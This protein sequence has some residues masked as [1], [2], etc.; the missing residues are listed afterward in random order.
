MIPIWN[1]TLLSID[2]AA[3]LAGVGRRVI[4]EWRKDHDFPSF[5]AGEGERGNCKIHRRLFEEWLGKRVEMR[6]GE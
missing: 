2:E 1:K 4:D 3:Q 6:I 5:R